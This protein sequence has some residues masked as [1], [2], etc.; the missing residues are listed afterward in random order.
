MSTNH[1]GFF[2]SVLIKQAAI[3][4]FQSAMKKLIS[5]LLICSYLAAAFQFATPYLSYFA[6]YDYFAE[7]LCINKHNPDIECNGM[8]QL[9]KMVNNQHDH[10]DAPRE[11]GVV[12]QKFSSSTIFFIEHTASADFSLKA[13]Q[14]VL[15]WHP[16]IDCQ[17]F[18]SP[19]TPPPQLG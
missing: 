3:C 15:S 14:S 12:I 10:S 2:Y 11:K 8:C 4:I 18:S 1:C 17:I 9:K 6:N 5:Y 7:E 19:P 16:Q 13:L